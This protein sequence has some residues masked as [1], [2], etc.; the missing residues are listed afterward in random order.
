MQS[1][2]KKESMFRIT[3]RRLAK[4]KLA[5]AGLIFIGF[6][7]VI[8]ILSP[9]IAPYP[10][11]QQDLDNVFLSP[12]LAH[13][14]G[15]DDLGR[16]I[17]SRLMYGGRYSLQIGFV[18]VAIAAVCGVAL[19]SIAGYF[20]GKVDMFIMRFLDIFQSI[21]SLLMSIAISATLGPGFTN[22]IIALSV[23]SVPA[24][25]RMTRASFLNI[26]GMEYVEAARSIKASN[27]RIIWKH[28]LPNAMS[29]IIV[30]A[31]MGVAQAILTAAALSFV[32][33][34]VQPPEP[35]WGAM[36]SAGRNYIRTNMYIV[37]FPG[38]TIMLT[39][40]SLNMLGDGLRDA[41]DPR[42]KN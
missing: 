27:G 1:S 38:L 8:A 32:G 42:L 36:L 26:R 19:G 13:P 9:Y 7:C 20:G 40:L 14:F 15:T 33:L 17:L 18:S 4:N 22:C 41:L 34:G 12:C 39:I 21:P 3:C 30:Q 35:E 25:A 24:Y 29:P 5:V 37:L 31:T 28:V 11:D 10:Y 6:I 23:S 16:D 2:R